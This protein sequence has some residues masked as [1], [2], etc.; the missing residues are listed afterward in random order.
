MKGN[1]FVGIT[2]KEALITP[3]S[4]SLL[5]IIRVQ[6]IPIHPS[7]GVR[8]QLLR[9]WQRIQQAILLNR[10]E[11]IEPLSRMS[12]TSQIQAI[13]N[14]EAQNNLWLDLNSLGGIN[15]KIRFCWTGMC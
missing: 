10:T 13:V 1:I 3:G 12:L 2:R 15:S 8:Q 4:H 11:V 9:C 5:T 6:Q 14:R 7:V